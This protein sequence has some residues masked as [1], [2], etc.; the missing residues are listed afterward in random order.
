MSIDE[1]S[2]HE[3]F[4]RLEQVLGPE[5]AST[6]MEHLPPAGWADVATKHDVATLRR[7]LSADMALLRSDLTS[8]MAVLRSDLTGQINKVGAD[9]SGEIALVRS[10]L[11]GEISLVRSETV[12]MK[13]EI[14]A[15]V[16]AEFAAQTRAM[17]L[18][19]VTIVLTMSGLVFA[20][21]R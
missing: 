13:H 9:L 16:R 6:L 2:R 4:L 15:T 21:A 12:S 20:L 17:F 10:D 14:L 11:G 1:R 3:L 18:A 5:P 19:I 8:D 7:E